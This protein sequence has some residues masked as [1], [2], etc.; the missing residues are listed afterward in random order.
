[1]TTQ[2]LHQ[3]LFLY[4]LYL[5]YFL[6]FIALTGVA[7]VSPDYLES[8]ESGLKYY[9]AIFLIL[10]FNPWARDNKTDSAAFDRRVA[11]SAGTFLLLSSALASALTERVTNELSSITDRTFDVFHSSAA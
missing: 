11:F 9:V 1:M 8:L 6:F 4:G 7:K 10:R 2:K 5:S 3:Q